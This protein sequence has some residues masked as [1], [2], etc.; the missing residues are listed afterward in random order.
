MDALVDSGTSLLVLAAPLYDKLMAELTW[1]LSTCVH[2]DKQDVLR[3]DRPPANDLSKLPWLV[4]NFIAADGEDFPLCM[5][6]EEFILESPDEERPGGAQCIPAFSRGGVAETNP[7]ILGMTFLRS[8]YTNFD[9]E[10]MQVGFARSSESPLP[11]HSMCHPQR[12]S[13]WV[14][15]VI[16]AA[17][18]VVFA[19]YVAFDTNSGPN[20]CCSSG[21][22]EA[23]ADGSHSPK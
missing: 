23:E 11:G 6:P 4:I 17:V 22:G 21:G 3:C 7:I 8:F 5:S 19:C 20:G 12:K 13:F 18:S 15:S 9:V 10:K 14:A 2:D 16:V 1:R